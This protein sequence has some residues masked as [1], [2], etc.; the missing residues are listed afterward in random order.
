MNRRIW[1][2][3]RAFQPKSLSRKGFR[4]LLIALLAPA[5]VLLSGCQGLY[6]V[7]LPGGVGNGSDSYRVDVRFA[8]ALDLV[9]QSAVKVGDVTVGSV[10]SIR[11][12][13]W[14]ALVQLR[15][16]KSVQLPANARADIQQTSLL[17]EKFVALSPPT[18]T[19]PVGRLTDGASIPLSRSGRDPEVEEVLGAMSLLLNGG[20]V[21]QLKTI[22]VELDS[23]LR[24]HEQDW[25][26]LVTRLQAVIGNL[27][28]HKADIVN[29]LAA[30]DRLSGRLAQQRQTL[31]RAL[32]TVPA[33]LQALSAQVP[34][35][36]RTLQDLQQLG[37]VGTQVITASKQDTLADL[38]ALQPTLQQLAAA[39]DALP[40]SL[41]V[42]FT[43]PF[44]DSAVNAMK[45]DYT[46][47]AV[48]ADLD[49]RTLYANLLAGA[50]QQQGS[51]GGA[52]SG[53]GLPGLP[54]VPAP[55]APS[56]PA[57]PAPGPSAPPT[58]PLPTPTLPI[59][60]G[61]S[62]A[63]TDLLLGGAA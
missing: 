11:L 46:N 34:Q 54:S 24:G 29:A 25:R 4:P 5:A 3:R 39:G 36:T 61:L 9:P 27:D 40:K 38:Q 49:F 45:G 62:P 47:L 33:G 28:A 22:S 30:L 53:G 8:D 63:V 12:D 58:L 37:Q 15:V 44:P 60:Y 17:G 2:S 43:Y 26:G 59:G 55:S 48:T 35:L 51:A 20:G 10:Q 6:G 14:T 57:Q 52:G 56:A 19:P 13:G 23:A 42:L 21:A 32:D 16:L 1:S 50:R 31:Q 7:D 18:G 41:Q